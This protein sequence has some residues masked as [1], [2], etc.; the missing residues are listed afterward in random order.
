MSFTLQTVCISL[1]PTTMA[2]RTE[3]YSLKSKRWKKIK[4]KTF[5]SKNAGPKK[6]FFKR[7]LAIK[8]LL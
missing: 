5:G 1:T 7:I 8:T 6:R 3:N 4:E 2:Q